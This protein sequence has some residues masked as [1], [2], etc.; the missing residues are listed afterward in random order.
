MK[1]VP[2]SFCP[3]RALQQVPKYVLHQ[4]LATQ[5]NIL[6]QANE[7]LPHN[8]Q[9][10]SIGCLCTGPWGKWVWVQESFYSHFSY[11]CSLVG[12][13]G[14]SHV[15][16]Q[17]YMF[18]GLTSQMQVLMLEVLDVGFRSYA[19]QSEALTLS[20]LLIMGCHTRG[21]IY[22]KT[23]FQPLPPSSTWACSHSRNAEKSLSQ[24]L[25]LFFFFFPSKSCSIH[26]CRF[27]VFMEGEWVQDPLIL[28]SSTTSS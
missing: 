8:V 28:P 1:I 15:G 10:P 9:Y 5:V 16:F 24:F 21:G 19:P 27:D 7:C 3:W 26:S 4:T 22:G 14:V 2:A 6:R 12:L 11:H 17:S 18:E 23:M 20:F 13:V 25:G